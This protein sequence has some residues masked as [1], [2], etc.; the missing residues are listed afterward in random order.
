M[1]KK[2]HAYLNPEDEIS[3]YNNGGTISY[4]ALGKIY[5]IKGDYKKAIH[6]FTLS[7]NPVMEAFIAFSYALQDDID[8]TSLYIQRVRI[9]TLMDNESKLAYCL[10]CATLYCDPPQYDDEEV[11]TYLYHCKD[12]LK[13][14]T[15]DNRLKKIFA[16][17]FYEIAKRY[18][19]TH[20]DQMTAYFLAICYHQG[21]GIRRNL[22]RAFDI[23]HELFDMGTNNLNILGEFYT[24][25]TEILINE[26]ETGPLIDLLAEIEQRIDQIAEF[27]G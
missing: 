20:H 26:T 2:Y 17:K 24:V 23:L 11:N 18:D 12:I 10:S 7:N 9:E 15:K 14:K 1:Q 4:F 13:R 19:E 25:C 27:Q 8:N 16:N 21:Y 5:L 6:Y 3:Y 22:R